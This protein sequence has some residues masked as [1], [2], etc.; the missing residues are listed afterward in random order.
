MQL[1][2]FDRLSILIFI[3]PAMWPFS[4]HNL[5]NELAAKSHP[6]IESHLIT[7]RDQYVTSSILAGDKVVVRGTHLTLLAHDIVGGDS[8]RIIGLRSIFWTTDHDNA[9][10]S[11][12]K[13]YNVDRTNIPLKVIGI[14]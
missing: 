8:A 13:L 10:S 6:V 9:S 3:L 1:L 4:I 7:Q 12:R 11:A 2:N 5:D 14:W